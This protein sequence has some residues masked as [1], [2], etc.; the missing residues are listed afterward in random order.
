MQDTFSATCPSY[1]WGDLLTPRI[2][3]QSRPMRL[4]VNAKDEAPGGEAWQPPAECKLSGP[5]PN[6]IEPPSTIPSPHGGAGGGVGL[7]A[8]HSERVGVGAGGG[9]RV[10][11][12]DMTCKLRW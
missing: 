10:A 3:L 9:G 4:D 12:R 8:D 5:N 2:P 7:D 11:G 1:E 6:P